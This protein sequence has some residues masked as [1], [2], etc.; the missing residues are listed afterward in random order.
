MF[1]LGGV[2]A[3]TA[4]TP[5]TIAGATNIEFQQ[6]FAA[7]NR[8]K[9]PA[10]IKQLV[11]QQGLDKAP[12]TVSFCNTGHWAATNW[13]VLS[14]VAGLAKVRLYPASL[15]EWTQAE[16]ALP[17]DNTPTRLQQI[18]NKFQQLVN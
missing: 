15:A 3:P 10:V 5:G 2:K 12:E 11:Q 1:Y 16:R 7:D 6:W 4:S 13:F 9:E 8:L 14:E 17:M 18:K